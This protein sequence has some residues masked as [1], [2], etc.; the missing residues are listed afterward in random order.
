MIPYWLGLL[1]PVMLV[2]ANVPRRH[3]AGV[4]ST[5]FVV[6]TLFIGLRHQVGGDWF[7]YLREFDIAAYSSFWDYVATSDPGYAI[8]NWFSYHVGGGIYLVNTV[9]GL[10]FL[11]GLVALCRRQPMPFVALMV[12]VPYMI[13]VLAMGYTRQAVALGLIM[14]GLRYLSDGQVRRYLL[15]VVLGALFHKSAVIMLPLAIFYRQQ[16]VALRLLGVGAFSAIMAYLFLS[17]HYERLWS[18]YVEVQMQSDGGLIRLMMNALPAI[19]LFVY[20]HRIREQWPDYRIWVTV[21]IVSLALLPLV[22]MASTAVDRVA[23]YLLPLQL[24][25]FARLPMLFSVVGGRNKVVVAIVVYY[26]LVLFVWL[27]YAS[28]AFAWLPYRNLIFLDLF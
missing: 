8:L 27:N 19:L 12:A 11:I 9:S 26:A 7:N 17:D 21:A 1:F 13:T 18:V 20:Y 25:V 14:L 16:G 22:G 23:L 28:H 5:V 3:Q 15:F 4:W 10:L 6:F 2:F 24:V